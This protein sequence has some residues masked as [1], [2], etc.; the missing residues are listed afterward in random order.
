MD[1]HKE[2]L[3]KLESL[4]KASRAFWESGVNCTG[5]LEY[6]FKSELVRAEDFLEEIGGK[7]RHHN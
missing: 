7:P 1:Y 4:A 6:Y 5:S 2:T 3:E